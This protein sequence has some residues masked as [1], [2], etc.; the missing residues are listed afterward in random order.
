MNYI[1][2]DTNV[3]IDFSVIEKIELPFLLP[4]TYIMY[5]EALDTEVVS[6]PELVDELLKAGLKPVEL[7]TEEFFY[8]AE[9]MMRYPKI[10]RF[11]STALAIAKKRRIPLLTGDLSL[12]RAAQEEEV[13]ILGTIG[14][15]DR[16]YYEKY[17]NIEE[18]RFCLENLLK[19]DERRLPAEEIKKRLD[20]EKVVLEENDGFE[21][22]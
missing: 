17:I 12:R 20:A 14:I 11:D 10:S 2:S 22:G 18:Y 15:L 16:L 5:K 13:E 6:P 19:H 8:A 4:D 3:W 7:T 21:G 9:C 1:S